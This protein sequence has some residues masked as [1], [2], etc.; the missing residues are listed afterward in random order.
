MLDV[1][2][3][4]P[5]FSSLFYEFNF[6]PTNFFKNFNF[7]TNIQKND[8]KL[9]DLTADFDTIFNEFDIGQIKAS[10]SDLD[11][12]AKVSYYFEYNV[13]KENDLLQNIENESK[14]ILEKSLF[15][16]V[17]NFST[18]DRLSF[19]EKLIT[20]SHINC[21]EK[22]ELSQ[23]FRLDI[24]TGKIFVTAFDFLQLKSI[25]YNII[26]DDIQ[27]ISI[28]LHVIA[29]DNGNPSLSNITNVVIH[30]KNSDAIHKTKNQIVDFNKKIY[31][32]KFGESFAEIKV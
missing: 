17:L 23:F 20:R 18:N 10:D 27:R 21:V 30:I 4:A 19:T 3:N 25:F 5:S 13:I 16:A 31:D 9:N 22:M 32:I 14:K 6:I 28:C 12:N 7:I 26:T 1:N 8:S 11:N 15:N 24:D 2:D 29:K